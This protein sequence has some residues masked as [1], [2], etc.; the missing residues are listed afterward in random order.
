MA[1][2]YFPCEDISKMYS[3][4]VSLDNLCD[5]LKQPSEITHIFHLRSLLSLVKRGISLSCFEISIIKI[6]PF[7]MQIF[8]F[9]FCTPSQSSVYL[10]KFLEI[11]QSKTFYDDGFQ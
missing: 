9:C 3:R 1:V 6:N 8:L 11:L 10:S 5:F 2:G 4:I 7:I